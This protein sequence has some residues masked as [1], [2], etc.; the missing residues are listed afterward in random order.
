MCVYAHGTLR[1]PNSHQCRRPPE[2]NRAILK[3]SSGWWFQPT[4]KI[5]V[6][7]GNLPQVGVKI[8]IF[9]ISNHHLVMVVHN[10][11]ILYQFLGIMGGIAEGHPLTNP[12]WHQAV[13]SLVRIWPPK[14]SQNNNEK[15]HKDFRVHPSSWTSQSHNIP[16]NSKHVR[17]VLLFDR[18]LLL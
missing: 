4:W 16:Q 13:W 14:P 9:Q 10:P 18:K 11:L 7:I 6:K 15:H 2:E 12:W 8:K 3:G 1:G 5:L 17:K